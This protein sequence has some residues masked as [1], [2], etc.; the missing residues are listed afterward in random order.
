[1]I[2]AIRTNPLRAALA[3]AGAAV[4]LAGLTFEHTYD[5]PGQRS[6][7]ARAWSGPDDGRRHPYKSF[8][9]A[10]IAIAVHPR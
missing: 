2:P 9:Q 10:L 1:M 8:S 7:T 3:A 5:E 4:L 6:A